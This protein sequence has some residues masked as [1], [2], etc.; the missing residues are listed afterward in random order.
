M[1]DILV[2]D[3]RIELRDLIIYPVGVEKLQAGVRYMLFV[4]REI[5]MDIRAMGYTRLTITGDRISGASPG[6]KVSLK[7]TL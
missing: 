4:R 3:N 2:E 6:R 7:E 1:A 5:E